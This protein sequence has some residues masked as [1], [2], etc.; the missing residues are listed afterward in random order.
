MG[1]QVNIVDL[2]TVTEVGKDI[3]AVLFQYPDTDGSIENFQT[4]V[5]KTHSAG[6]SYLHGHPFFFII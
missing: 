6:V 3:S 5:D 2:K 4:L 1:F